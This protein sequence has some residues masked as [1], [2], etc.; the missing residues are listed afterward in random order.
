LLTTL[1]TDVRKARAI[2][3]RVLRALTVTPDG[4]SYRISGALNLSA[5]G[6]PGVSGNW[7]SGGVI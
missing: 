6:D 7:S 5:V 1:D 4:D 3:M 2:L